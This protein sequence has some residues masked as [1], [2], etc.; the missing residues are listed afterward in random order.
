MVIQQ[1]DQT[2]GSESEVTFVD[3]RSVVQLVNHG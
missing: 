3:T 2:Y 1:A